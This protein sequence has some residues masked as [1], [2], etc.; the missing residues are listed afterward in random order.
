MNIVLEK[1]K[2][3]KF[4][5]INDF[6]DSKLEIK[7]T[8]NFKNNPKLYMY[9][10]KYTYPDT[11][12]LDL[13]L[14][15]PQF[16]VKYVSHYKEIDKKTV[17]H[18]HFK[19]DDF[20]NF[21]KKIQLSIDPILKNTDYDKYIIVNNISKILNTEKFELKHD[22]S[23]RIFVHSTKKN[24]GDIKSITVENNANL[25]DQLEKNFKSLYKYRKTVNDDDKFNVL[26]KCLFKIK[27]IVDDE[28][29]HIYVSLS[30]FDIELKYAFN[31]TELLL[32]TKVI[33]T[34]VVTKS[35]II[36]L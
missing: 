20:I 23:K 27:I 36:V 10:L 17:F 6:N 31:R 34:K 9:K 15:S 2:S 11:S 29:K 4:I 25:K 3:I 13:V 18:M 35:A 30:P 32:D 1:L 22:V 5:D 19:N 21:L 7:K 24:G 28:Y 14:M 12:K 8:E 26:L 16:I 33:S